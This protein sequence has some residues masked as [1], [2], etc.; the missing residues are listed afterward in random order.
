MKLNLIKIFKV[1]AVVSLITFSLLPQDKGLSHLTREFENYISLYQKNL[2]IPSISAGIA[3][4]DKIIWTGAKGYTDIENFVPATTKSVYRI[5]SISKSLTAIAILQLAEQKKISLDENALKYIP[6]YPTKKWKFTIRQLLNHTAG[7]RNYKLGEFDSKDNYPS[8]RDAISLI[9]RDSLE[10]EPG[11]KYLY[12]TLGYNLLAAIIETVSGMT[13]TDYMVKNIF[14]PSGMSS[15]FFEFQKDIIYYR[16]KG[17]TK[18]SYRKFQN[19]ALADLSLKFAGGGVISTATDLL[20]F[21]IALL[22]GKLISQ[23]WIDSIRVP[24]KLKNG[25]SV[26]YGLGFSISSDNKGREYI[27][28][29][30][31]GTGFASQLLIYPKEKIAAVQLINC[32]DR[33]PGRPAMDLVRLYLQEVITPPLTPASDYLLTVT[34]NSGIDSAIT[35]LKAL[36]LDSLSNIRI[37]EDELILFGNDLL[38]IKKNGEAIILFKFV[39]SAFPEYFKGYIGLG[40]AY[41]KDGNKGLALRNFRQALRLN[42]KNN[43]V[44]DM[45]KKL[46]GG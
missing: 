46:E 4:N 40:E 2:S 18:N 27:Y 13:Y 31:S 37:N 9:I 7:I 36:Q 21:S 22:N 12:T 14:I 26:G 20:K 23:Q 1:F 35:A 32:I 17:Y 42:P 10:Y 6:Y 11:T 33:N 25:I 24:A 15:T 30:G 3:A 34:M 28:H 8:V 43:Y 5:A 16:A 41:L 44:S 29:T 45:I 19:A 38:N 39:T